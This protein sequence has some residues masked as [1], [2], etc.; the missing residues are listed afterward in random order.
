MKTI[1]IQTNYNNKLGCKD[2]IHIDRAPRTPI[3]SKDLGSIIELRTSDN[4]HPPVQKKIYSLV[5]FKLGQTF[6]TQS[7]PSHGMDAC[8]FIEWWK[9]QY[10]E[11][12]GTELAVYYYRDPE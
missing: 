8:Q 7:I 11:G 3:P 10:G 2:F 12:E 4:S 9:S 5:R 6:D 1:Y